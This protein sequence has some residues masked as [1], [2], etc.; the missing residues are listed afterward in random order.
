M[1]F[2]DAHH[3]GHCEGLLNWV[4]VWGKVRVSSSSRSRDYL[5]ILGVGSD[6][7][8][9]N[10]FKEW[11]RKELDCGN[12]KMGGEGRM[13]CEKELKTIFQRW[14]Q[15]HQQYHFSEMEPGQ[16]MVIVLVC[17]FWYSMMIMMTCMKTLTKCNVFFCTQVPASLFL[18]IYKGLT[19]HYCY[20]MMMTMILIIINTITLWR[21]GT[22]Y[23]TVCTDDEMPFS[24]WWRELSWG[25]VCFSVCPCLR[26]VLVFVNELNGCSFGPIWWT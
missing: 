22:N 17:I 19:V 14:N 6:K 1:A 16:P 20:M 21:V 13:W 26:S 24:S 18:T 7:T 9:W 15:A 5:G 8:R 10:V 25:S 12:G 23:D 11:L 3:R 4:G 2:R